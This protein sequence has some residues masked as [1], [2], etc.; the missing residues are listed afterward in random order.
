MDFAKDLNPQQL[1]AV[2][3]TDGPLLIIAGAGSGK[4]RV[5]TYRIAYLLEQGVSPGEILAITF[6]NKAAREMLER[7]ESLVGNTDGMWI[8]T[9]HSAC[10]RMLRR[11]GKLVDCLPGFSIYDDQDQLLVI[12][13]CLRELDMDDKKY[14][15]RAV[16]A[17][18]SK[19]KNLLQGPAEFAAEAEDGYS[20]RVAEVFR[21]Y[22]AK[23]R[24]SNAL[25]FDD[26]LVKAVELLETQPQ[27]LE[28][29]PKPL[30]IH[31]CR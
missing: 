20:R 2:R 29:L 7:V 31:T 6:T 16:L 8:S 14:H 13:S 3:H 4:T 27:V 5:L 9:F 25:D 12:K 1:E 23:L 10:V 11:H 22:N 28:L 24:A 15:P 21:L 17:A 18:I 30:S 26:L 19:A